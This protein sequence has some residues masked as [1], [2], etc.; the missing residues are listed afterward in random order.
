[1]FPPHSSGKQSTTMGPN[2]SGPLSQNSTASRSTVQTPTKAGNG[3]SLRGV[4]SCRKAGEY[5]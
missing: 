1:M 2:S 3:S 5:R 4:S